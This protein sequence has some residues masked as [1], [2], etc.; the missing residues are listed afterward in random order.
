MPFAVYPITTVVLAASVLAV[1][2]VAV[3]AS[4]GTHLLRFILDFN[5]QGLFIFDTIIVVFG[6]RFTQSDL[7]ILEHAALPKG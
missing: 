6:N 1:S 2:I 7:A 4:T 3:A 5:S